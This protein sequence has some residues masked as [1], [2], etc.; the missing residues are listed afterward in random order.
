MAIAN[1]RLHEINIYIAL[2][3]PKTYTGSF[4]I[5]GI[6]YNELKIINICNVFRFGMFIHLQL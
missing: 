1:E 2:Q 4:L 6:I 3:I 5:E